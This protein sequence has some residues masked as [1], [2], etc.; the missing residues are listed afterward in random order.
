MLTPRSTRWLSGLLAAL[1][2]VGCRCDAPQ[3]PVSEATSVDAAKDAP[4]R[5]EPEAVRGLPAAQARPEGFR[6][7][8]SL[9]LFVSERDPRARRFYYEQL[10]DEIREV[11]ATDVSLVVRWSQRDVQATAIAPLEGVTSGDDVLTEVIAL[12]RARGLRVFL[13]PILHLG[14]R[15]RGQ[16][17]G[18]L[19]PVDEVAWW[20]SYEAFILHYARIAAAQEVELFA[21]GSELVSMERQA[22]RWEAL[23]REVRGV[24]GGE[25]TYSANWDH[26]EPVPFWDHLDVVG[27]TAYHELSQEPD[28]DEQA[29][30]AG[31]RPFERRLKRWAAAQDRRY[32]FTEVGFP[33]HSQGAA[34]PW[35][36]TPRGEPDAAL[37]LRC[38]RSMFRV[39]NA[40]P[41]LTGVFI[42]N[43][44]GVGG[45][46]DRG[47][48]PRGKP[49]EQVIRR[50]YG[51]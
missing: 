20:A 24:Y 12:A 15:R 41:R 9:G 51:R 21:V 29:L 27:V 10:L 33:S 13:M 40:D 46:S 48:T 49:A 22:E 36:Y 32:I 28:P 42:W 31:W 23:I 50:W 37:Q 11:G 6:R 35:D 16:W 38:Y 39:W 34:R 26:F 17:R 18:T 19:K 5:R 43:W 14:S 8:V 4:R 1:V 44:F 3:R 30:V 2:L 47:Y 7:G 25:L 45:A